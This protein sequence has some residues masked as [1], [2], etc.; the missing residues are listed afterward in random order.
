MHQRSVI[1]ILRNV[2]TL[3]VRLSSQK[4]I[5]PH[6][7]LTLHFYILL[8]PVTCGRD[9][10]IRIIPG[11]GEPVIYTEYSCGLRGEGEKCMTEILH[12]G[13]QNEQFHSRC[14][15]NGCTKEAF[16]EERAYW[17]NMGSQA[18]LK[19]NSMTTIGCELQNKL[20]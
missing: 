17:E 6:N 8:C 11:D 1:A 2:T 7:I 5:H 4:K 12:Q 19:V 13:E 18:S 10:W 3:L 14:A 9:A 20:H 15:C 16:E